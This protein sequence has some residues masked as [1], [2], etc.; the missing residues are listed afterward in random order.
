MVDV[1]KC[2]LRYLSNAGG[3]FNRTMKN[4]PLSIVP[5][6]ELQKNKSDERQAS[7]TIVAHAEKAVD[8]ILKT[9]KV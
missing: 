4:I 3:I 2:L 5:S 9:P 6:F 1:V 8:I 7:L